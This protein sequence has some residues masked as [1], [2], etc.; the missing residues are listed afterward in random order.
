MVKAITHIIKNDATAG[1]LI[2]ANI[3]NDTKKVYPIIATQKEALPL[4]TVWQVGRKPEF[5]RGQRPS[6]FNMTYEVHVFATDYDEL[7]DISVAIIDAIEEADISNEINGVRFTDRI[8][9]TDMRDVGY[10]E[11]Y[12]AYSK[13]L[14]FE[15]PVYEDQAT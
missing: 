2:G 10:I 8:R 5:C 14:L 7:N 15:A 6:T 12:K 13:M 1:P 9:N 3:A 4:V 11:E